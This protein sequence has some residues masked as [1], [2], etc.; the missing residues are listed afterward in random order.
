MVGSTS[1]ISD[2][3]GNKSDV[4]DEANEENEE[5]DVEESIDDIR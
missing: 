1:L 2:A 4:A 3:D 5:D